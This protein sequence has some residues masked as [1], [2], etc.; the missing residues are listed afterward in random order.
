M[1][2]CFRKIKYKLI[3]DVRNAVSLCSND[4]VI[5]QLYQYTL[6][7]SKHVFFSKSILNSYPMNGRNKQLSMIIVQ[8]WTFE[9]GYFGADFIIYP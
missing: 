6:T 2:I 7:I 9:P 8:M 3:L 1:V 5:K 4:L